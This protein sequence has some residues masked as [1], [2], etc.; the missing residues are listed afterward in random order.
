MGFLHFPCIVQVRSSEGLH[1]W[2]ILNPYVHWLGFQCRLSRWGHGQVFLGL[3]Q[4]RVGIS[5]T[6]IPSRGPAIC[7]CWNRCYKLRKPFQFTVFNE[8]LLLTSFPPLRNWEDAYLSSVFLGFSPIWACFEASSPACSYFPV[9][10]ILSN[11]I[12]ALSV[13]CA[14][15]VLGGSTPMN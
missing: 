9:L 12:S 10:A 15:K 1:P 11:G 5:V 14:C 3:C 6:V 13:Y 2:I 7:S 4:T 8:L